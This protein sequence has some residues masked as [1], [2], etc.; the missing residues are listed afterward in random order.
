LKPRRVA[1]FAGSRLMRRDCR[2]GEARAI[3]VLMRKIPVRRRGME[4]ARARLRAPRVR[5]E[6]AIMRV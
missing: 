3:P 2:G 4:D 5:R 6:E 1:L